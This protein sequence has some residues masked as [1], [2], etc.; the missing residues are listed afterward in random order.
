[1]C[2]GCTVYVTGTKLYLG[3]VKVNPRLAD[4]VPMWTV[5]LDQPP[6]PLPSPPPLKLLEYGK[7][8]AAREA[9]PRPESQNKPGKGLVNNTQTPN[10]KPKPRCWWDNHLIYSQL[11]QIRVQ[12]LRTNKP[13]NQARPTENAWGH[14]PE[15]LPNNQ[16]QVS[17]LKTRN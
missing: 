13:R 10:S 12:P 5:L 1:M 8:A 11:L 9:W 6:R 15:E 4:L 2:Y 7:Y 17:L 3:V 14:C 16:T